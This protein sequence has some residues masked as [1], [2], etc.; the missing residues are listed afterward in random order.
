MTGTYLVCLNKDYVRHGALDLQKL[1]VEIDMGDMIAEEYA[2]VPTLA[3]EA[4]KV[5]NSTDEPE[6]D[7]WKNCHKPYDCAF[8]N[9]CKRLHGIPENEPTVFDLYRANFDVQLKHYRVGRIRFAEL[10]HEK[11]ADAQRCDSRDFLDLIKLFLVKSEKLK[12]KSA[13]SPR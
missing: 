1:F 6:Q 4:V 3:A 5:V 10:L 2:H 11:L 8:W 7:L 13:I 12:I 9:Y